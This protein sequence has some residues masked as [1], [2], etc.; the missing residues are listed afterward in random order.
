MTKETADRLQRFYDEHLDFLEGDRK[1]PPLLDRLTSEEHHLAEE[2]LTSL[3]ATRGVDPYASAPSVAELFAGMDS[4]SEKSM[5]AAD[6]KTHEQLAQERERP[7]TETLSDHGDKSTDPLDWSAPAAIPLFA[8]GEKWPRGFTCVH[9]SV[10]YRARNVGGDDEKERCELARKVAENCC[11][12]R[13][14]KC[15]KKLLSC[16]Y[17]AC[18]ACINKMDR[19]RL[20]RRVKK[21]T[22]VH[23][24]DYDQPFVYWD[25]NYYNLENDDDDDEFDLEMAFACYP[26]K[27]R[28]DAEEVVYQVLEEHHEGAADEIPKKALDELQSH[29]DSWCDSHKIVSYSDKKTVVVVFDRGSSAGDEDG[30]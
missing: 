21:A 9:C 5:M 15:Q 20:E 2:W 24:K 10:I 23:F 14:S 27:F 17:T 29:L 13:C 26:V 18:E 12:R 25:G 7:M 8:P 4:D 19:E 6:T 28:I 3:K 11:R 16:V 1:E 22:K 30:P